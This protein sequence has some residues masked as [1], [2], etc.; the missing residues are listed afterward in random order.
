VGF[1]YLIC[2]TILV[3][4]QKNWSQIGHGFDHFFHVYCQ[5]WMKTKTKE[6]L[7]ACE[8]IGI[9]GGSGL[10]DTLVGHLTDTQMQVVDTPFGR[11]SGPVV[12]GQWG[13]RRVAF[14]NRH[15]QGHGFSPS[16]VPY[17]ANIFAM[18]QLGVHTLLAT[19]AVGSL[20]EAIEPGDLVI[21]DQFIDKT[22]RRRSSF[23]NHCAVHCE[24]ADPVCEG[25]TESLN[26][27]ALTIPSKTHD[28]GTYVCMEGPQFSTRAESRMHRLWG[29]DL[30]GMTAMPEAKLAREAQMCYGL[31]ALVSDYDCWLPHDASKGKHALLE[32]ILGNLQMATDNCTA[33]IEAVLKSEEALVCEDC[34]CRKSLQLAVWTQDSD[35]TAEQRAQL[36]PLFE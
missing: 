6:I 5:Q 3:S 36:A 29:G 4:N 19:G 20:Q 34:A 35:K 1:I 25:L 22:F 12:I 17:A 31:I 2:S 33:L 28:Q 15:G 11:P 32:E 26:R 8:M 27:V 30:I 13:D 16:T 21:V 23:F 14:L 7:M 18:K 24:L 9:I 10:G